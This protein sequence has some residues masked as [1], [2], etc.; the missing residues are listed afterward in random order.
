MNTKK[1]L[2]KMGDLKNAR[3]HLYCCDQV[4]GVAII[5]KLGSYPENL[6]K[7]KFENAIGITNY[8]YDLHSTK[9]N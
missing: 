2:S 3:K 8:I 6:V 5:D 7:T 1:F 9:D 4:A